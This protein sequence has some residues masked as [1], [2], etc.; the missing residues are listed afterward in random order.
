MH[1]AIIK[2]VEDAR[3]VNLSSQILVL[4]LHGIAM[5]CL[6][7]NVCRSIAYLEQLEAII[8]MPDCFDLQNGSEEFY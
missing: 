7:R 2:I 8:G 1:Q 5:Y 3:S 4:P 6:C